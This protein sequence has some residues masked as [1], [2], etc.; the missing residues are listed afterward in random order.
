MDE[1]PYRCRKILHQGENNQL[2]KEKMVRQSFFRQVGEIYQGL[3]A[4]SDWPA[5]RCCDKEHLVGRS[6][7]C[8]THKVVFPPYSTLA[9]PQL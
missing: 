1:F 2:H 6:I 5:L 8:K 3:L 9:W 7:V 4:G